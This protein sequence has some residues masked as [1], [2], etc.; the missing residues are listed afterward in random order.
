MTDVHTT[1]QKNLR[2]LVT[3]W[4]GASP[5][6]KKLGYSN[7]SFVSQMVHGHRPITDANA[8]KI[9]KALGLVAGWLDR[10]HH[11]GGARVPKSSEVDASLFSRIVVLTSAA[12]EETGVKLS[13]EK[14]TELVAYLY[15]RA[16]TG[17]KVDEQS[18]RR[19]LR[20]TT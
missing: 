2:E 10:E 5:L 1:R 3:Q 16:I 20:L 4:G 15:E 19:L 12:V 18:V 9:E 17:E 6:G 13:V 7:A 8:R 14:F 11:G